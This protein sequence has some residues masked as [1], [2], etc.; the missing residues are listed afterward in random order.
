MESILE[1]VFRDEDFE[2]LLT[3]GGNPHNVGRPRALP[4]TVP[5]IGSRLP[6]EGSADAA[7]VGRALLRATARRMELSRAAALVCS[8]ALRGTGPVCHPEVEIT[9]RR[10]AA[11]LSEYTNKLAIVA[12]R[13]AAISI[14]EEV[15]RISSIGCFAVRVPRDTLH[16]ILFRLELMLISIADCCTTLRTPDKEASGDVAGVLEQLV[17]DIIEGQLVRFRALAG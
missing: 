9:L 1:F 4:E 10:I 11:E 15:T 5:G 13:G 16:D 14:P 17:V 2:A 6:P 12:D 8:H 7:L 3:T